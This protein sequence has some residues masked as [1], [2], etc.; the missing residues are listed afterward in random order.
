MTENKSKYL[1]NIEKNSLRFYD[2]IPLYSQIEK[3]LKNNIENNIFNNRG[4][5]PSEQ[6]LAV[7]FGVSINTIKAAIKNLISQ[8]YLE[9]KTGK[10]TFVTKPKIE[11]F[12]VQKLIGSYEEFEEKGIILYSKILSLYSIP[13]S[14][15]V[16]DKL[17]I[18]SNQL[19]I[20]LNRLRY[21]R[22]EPIV[23][24]ES[25]YPYDLCSKLLEEDLSNKSVYKVLKNKFGLY[26][27]SAKRSIEALAANREVAELLNISINS[28]IQYVESVAKIS[29]GIPLEY[30]RAFHRADYSKFEIE[31]SQK[32][33]V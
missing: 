30:Y 32:D 13:A 24:A 28:P 22:D 21:L 15:I 1:L 6:E 26:I 31:I 7:S 33:F 10:G 3:I 5:L 23:L 9:R 11:E 8:G 16:A 18:K 12:W 27:V 17:E 19:V 20:Y 29:T 25:Y 2:S 14:Q 4:K